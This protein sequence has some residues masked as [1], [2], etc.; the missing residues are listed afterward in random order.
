MNKLLVVLMI[1]FVGILI[2]GC[3]SQPAAPATPTAAPTTAVPTPVPTTVAPTPVPTNATVNVTKTATPTPTPQPS[4]TIT[5][6]NDMTI[7]PGT[8][9]YIPVGGKVIWK[10]N[11]PFKPHG[12][13]AIDVQTA[14]Y[15]GGMDTNVI[16]YGKTLEVTF[17]KKGAYDYKTVFQQETTGKIIV[18]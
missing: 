13:Q 17:T 4:V 11:D 18:T 1:L 3:T 15:F 16:P 12:V 5:F 6:N 7:T 10:N 14:A 8:T 9:V 2:C